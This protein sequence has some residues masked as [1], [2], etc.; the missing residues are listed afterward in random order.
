MVVRRVIWA[1][2]A[3]FCRVRAVAVSVS[4]LCAFRANVVRGGAV[5]GRVGLECVALVAYLNMSISLPFTLVRGDAG[6]E[7][8]ESGGQDTVSSID[9]VAQ[10]FNNM[11]IVFDF[12]Y[13]RHFESVVACF[14]FS[15]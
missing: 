7:C 15:Q 13:V 11:C 3:L 8:V 2:E 1:V 12:N 10:Q 14:Q 9:V 4:C 6:V 5:F